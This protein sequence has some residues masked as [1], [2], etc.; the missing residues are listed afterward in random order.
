MIFFNPSTP[1]TH[2]LTDQPAVADV[3]YLGE[4]CASIRHIR[5]AAG[6]IGSVREQIERCPGSI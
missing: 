1:V 6:Q 4:V 5:C 2:S 3:L